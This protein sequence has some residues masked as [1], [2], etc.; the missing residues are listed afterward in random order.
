MTDVLTQIEGAVATVTVNRPQALNAINTAVLEG[1]DEAFRQVEE[2]PEVRAAVLTGAGDKAFVAG[3]DIKAMAD[4]GPEEA[5][6]F[7]AFGHRVFAA[8]ERSSKIW[9]AAVDGFCLGGGCELAM[10]CDWINASPGSKFGQPEVKLGLIPGFGGTI[11]LVRRVGQA[12]ALELCA[13]ADMIDGD[14]A[15]RIGLANHLFEAGTVLE[16]SLKQAARIAKQG[17]LAVANAKRVV[18]AGVDL[19][20][21]R[22]NAME[23]Q[24]FG[25]HFGTE[26]GKEGMAA[27]M[28]KRRAEFKGR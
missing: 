13:T 1:L 10:A 19:P 4:F 5:R 28:A 27:F 9:I 26:D 8:M 22:G 21:E 18:R 23:Q 15:Y 6:Q 16:A 12:R 20:Q 2:A 11:R 3:A 14:E 7:S 24:A 17:P 25:L